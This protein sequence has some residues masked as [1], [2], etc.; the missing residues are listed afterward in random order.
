MRVPTAPGIG[1]TVLEKDIRKM[2]LRTAQV[3]QA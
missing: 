3:R 1:V 2:A